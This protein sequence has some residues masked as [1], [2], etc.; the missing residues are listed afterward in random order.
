MK[1]VF[2][3]GIG[4]GIGKGLALKFL[5]EGYFVMGTSIVGD[6]DYFD[7]NLKVF[8][9]DLYENKSI[10]KCAESVKSFGK[11]IDIFINNAGVLLDDGE[12]NIVI[13]KLRRTLQVNLIGAIDI[14][15]RLLCIIKEGGHIINISSSAGSLTN[16]HHTNYPAY[17]ISKA[18]LNMF[19]SYLAF[20]L[21]DKVKVSSIHPGRVR[22]DMGGGEG[23][24]DVEESAE[25]IFD[26]ATKI[27]LE[28]GQFWYKSKKFPW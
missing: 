2:I 5:K 6:I 21:G 23:D 12:P 20:K 28:T 18:A 4:Q 15:Q 27:S 10:E 8:Q 26:T 19:T 22:T 11:N 24:M 7:D 17:K 14:T 3:T 9:L 16:I 13:D 1:T 25:Y